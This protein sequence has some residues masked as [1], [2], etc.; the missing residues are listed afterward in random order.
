MKTAPILQKLAMQRAMYRICAVNDIML[1]NNKKPG[2]LLGHVVRETN[3]DFSILKKKTR[4]VL[5]GNP[6][7]IGFKLL[8][9]DTNRTPE[10][11]LIKFL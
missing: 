10:L 6:L 8:M 3:N 2:I 7:E 9:V 11:L 4:Y 1:R 5:H